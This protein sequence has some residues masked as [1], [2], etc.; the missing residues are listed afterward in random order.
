MR[1]AMVPQST[2]EHVGRVNAPRGVDGRK[3]ASGFSLVEVLVAL[4]LL[5]VGL[6]GTATLLIEALAGDRVALERTRAVALAGDMLERIRANRAAAGAYDTSNG[7]VA[8]V[9]DPACEQADVGC[10]PEVMAS[11]DLR[12]WLDA[13]ESQL[14][15]GVGTVEIA[16]LPQ[17]GLRCTVRVSWA[18]SGT[19]QPSLYA[20]ETDT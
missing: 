13:I 4:V 19:G 5:A 10:R 11:H 17:G 14:P 8:P 6:L 9:R 12:N 1:A 16:P 20:L 15:R 2:R 18:R 3:C 7:A